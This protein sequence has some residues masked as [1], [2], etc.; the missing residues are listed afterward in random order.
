MQEE[1]TREYF[2]ALLGNRAFTKTYNV[3]ELYITC[4]TLTYKESLLLT[5]QEN[6]LKDNP[7]LIPILRLIYHVQGDFDKDAI[8][9]VHSTVTLVNGLMD[10]ADKVTLERVELLRS[11]VM[12]FVRLVDD[13]RLEIS[14]PNFT[15]GNGQS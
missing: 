6:L 4:T 14:Q 2:R 13:L 8:L 11:I 1:D 10:I 15:K 5:E 9:K 12:E 7:S 3:N